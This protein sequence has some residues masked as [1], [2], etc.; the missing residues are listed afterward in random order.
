MLTRSGASKRY[1]MPAF[2]LTGRPIRA[3]LFAATLAL[4]ISAYAVR[5]Q[6]KETAKPAPGA[7]ADKSGQRTL[8]IEHQGWEYNEKDETSDFKKAV[9]T[10][11]DTI[12]HA[13]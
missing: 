8:N 11:E 4:G 10:D 6:A 7:A 13:D 9:I 2:A 1:K 12:I 3:L 5:Q